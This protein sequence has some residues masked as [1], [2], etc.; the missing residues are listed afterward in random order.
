M[1]D[2]GAEEGRERKRERKR[3]GRRKG[4]AGDWANFGL[5]LHELH[6]SS[7]VSRGRCLMVAALTSYE[8]VHLSWRM[9]R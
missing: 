5:G 2:E 1:G 9:S 6:P 3:N 4:Q 8:R 7:L